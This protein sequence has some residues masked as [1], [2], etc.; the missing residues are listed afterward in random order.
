MMF[1]LAGKHILHD[2]PLSEY[3]IFKRGKE[4]GREGER[5]GR[6]ERGERRGERR[7]GRGERGEERG[8]RGSEFGIPLRQMMFVLAG[9]HILHDHPLSEYSISV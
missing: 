2:H 9:K 7:E 1:V 8:E 6:G 4:G 5:E 3:S